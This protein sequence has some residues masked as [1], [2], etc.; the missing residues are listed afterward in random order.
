MTAGN[1]FGNSLDPIPLDHCPGRKPR[2]VDLE[3][4]SLTP[5]FCAR[6]HQRLV[7]ERYLRLQGPTGQNDEATSEPDE[8]HTPPL[9]FV[10]D[11]KMPKTSSNPILR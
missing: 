2:A 6:R 10:A 3:H 7:D 8:L 1:E 4:E 9:N 5:W 11:A